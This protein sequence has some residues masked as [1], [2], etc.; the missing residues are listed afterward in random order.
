MRSETRNPR[1]HYAEITEQI[2][3]ALEAGTPPWRQPWDSAKAGGPSMPQNAITGAR[4]R[5]I[6][7]LTLGMSPLAFTTPDDR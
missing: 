6:N 4:Y 2:I 3:A 5:G 1:D 7:V